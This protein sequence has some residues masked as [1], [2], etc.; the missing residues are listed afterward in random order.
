MNELNRSAFP[1]PLSY[2]PISHEVA[3]QAD[4]PVRAAKMFLALE[5]PSFL[6]C[7]NRPRV[8]IPQELRDRVFDRDKYTCRY[9]GS[10]RLSPEQN[11]SDLQLDH[12]VPWCYGG[13]NQLENL[14]VACGSCNQT[15]G[16]K[17]WV[18]SG[19]EELLAYL[20]DCIAYRIETLQAFAVALT[21]CD[22]LDLGERR[23]VVQPIADTARN[24]DQEQARP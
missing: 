5:D 8:L 9:C 4:A 23:R 16:P 19:Y 11:F 17:C 12:V 24:A 20:R 6:Y 13:G 2:L 1:L 10:G 7:A 3:E 14:V 21:P 15:K 18:P 22:Q